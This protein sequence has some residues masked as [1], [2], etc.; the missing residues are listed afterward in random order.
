M[1]QPRGQGAHR[2]SRQVATAPVE[3][4]C[5]PAATECR[6][7]TVRIL[8]SQQPIHAK[9]DRGWP[10]SRMEFVLRGKEMLKC[11]E[12]TGRIIRVRY[13]AGEIGPTPTARLRTRIA[14]VIAGLTIEQPILS[15]SAKRILLHLAGRRQR[16]DRQRR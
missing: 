11:Y 1:F 2:M 13:T 6:P 12:R 9:T 16:V 15:P 3:R 14:V 10:Q 8:E 5:S 7:P 4:Q